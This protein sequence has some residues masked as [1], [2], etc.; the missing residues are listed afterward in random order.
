MYGGFAF[1]GGR[2]YFEGVEQC[3]FA[4]EV[5]GVSYVFDAVFC[6]D[7]NGA[8]VDEVL[9]NENTRIGIKLVHQKVSRVHRHQV[10]L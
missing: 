2:T 9:M 3:T 1:D 6:D 10:S 7:A 8:R 4:E 5:T